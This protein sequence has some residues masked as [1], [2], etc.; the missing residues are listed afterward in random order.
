MSAPLSGTQSPARPGASSGLAGY[1][2]QLDVSVWTALELMLVR[3][4]AQE[5][6]LEPLSQ[7]DIEATIDPASPMLSEAVPLEDYRLVVQCKLDNTGPWKLTGL[8]ALLSHGAR[9]PSAKAQLADPKARY[10][11]IS[12]ADL[13]GLARNLQVRDLCEWPPADKMPKTLADALGPTDAAGRIAVLAPLPQELVGWRTHQVLTERFH[14]PL[15][16]VAECREAL[17]QQ[18]WRRLLGDLG[19]L[20]TRQQIESLL[21][22]FGGYAGDAAILE[23]FV[24]PTNWTQ[25]KAALAT[26]HAV[27]IT[28]PSGT[29]KTHT[30]RAL[31]AHVQKELPGVD[32]V[33]ITGG[34]EKIHLYSS[35]VVF[36]IEDPWG[37]FRSEPSSVPWNDRISDLL[38]TARPDRLF[39]ITSRSDV[40]RESGPK[41]LSANWFVQLE[42][43]HYRRTERYRLFENR[44]PALPP[45]GQRAAIHYQDE[46]L[47]EL[48]TPLEMQRYFDA[49]SEGPQPEENEAEFAH[50]CL[51]EA[52]QGSIEMAILNNLQRRGDWAWALF[53]WG[54]MKAHPRLSYK[55]LQAVQA[56]LARNDVEFEDG[57]YPFVNF[58][59]GGHQLRQVATEITYYHPRVEVGLG[60]ALRE[61]PQLGSRI[62]RQLIEVL[63]AQDT[64]NS[65]WGREG[66]ARIIQAVQNRPDLN[67]FLTSDTV[68][69]LDEWIRTCL[70]KP[71]EGF[72]DDLMLA[73]AVGSEACVPAEVVRWLT[74]TEPDEDDFTTMW[75]LPTRSDKWYETIRRDPTTQVICEAFVR[76]LL[77]GRSPYVSPSLANHIR[78]LAPD[79]TGAFRDAALSIV[80]DGYHSGANLIVD[81][82]LEDLDGFLPVVV[83]AIVF[84]DELRKERDTGHWLAILNGEYDEEAAEY[85]AQSEG[86]RGHT[87]D[88][89]LTAYVSALRS[90]RGW[91]E[92]RS[93]PQAEGLRK[94]WLWVAFRDE[95]TSDDELKVLAEDCIETRFESGLWDHAMGR[96]RDLFT[97]RLL[98]CLTTGCHDAISRQHAT[99]LMAHHLRDEVPSLTN[100]LLAARQEY[101][102]LELAC[103]LGALQANEDDA[104]A[105]AASLTDL[106]QLLPQPLSEVAAAISSDHRHP[107]SQEALTLLENVNARDNNRLML[108]QARALHAHGA[109][110]SP[111]LETLIRATGNDS[112]EEIKNIRNAV[113]LAITCGHWALVERALSHRFADVRE[114]ALRALAQQVS[115]GPMPANLLDCVADKGQ[116]VRSALIRLIESHMVP[117]HL[118]VL[119][120][121]SADTWSSGF[122]PYEG[123][124]YFTVAQQAAN[125]LLQWLHIDDT[126]AAAILEVSKQTAD[127]DVARTLLS[128]LVR[129]G[130]DDARQRVMSL[131]LNTGNPPRHRLAAEALVQESSQVSESLAEQIADGQLLHRAPGVAIP[132]ARVVGACASAQR[133]STAA[134]ALSADSR[135]QALLIPMWFGARKQRAALAKA[136]IARLPSELGSLL[137]AAAEGAT[138][139]PRGALESLGDLRVTEEIVVVLAEIFEPR[140]AKQGE[141]SD[142]V[143]LL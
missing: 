106:L 139:L 25:L 19:G 114:C 83:A 17:R 103:D 69:Q 111:L 20:W 113:E 26:R 93:H 126:S 35:P 128:S 129:N 87:A 28:G 46:A 80:D 66:A 23:G 61:K 56:G 120:R 9:R 12:N 81:G 130:T 10:L 4:L 98:D 5:L 123:K 2:Y 29:G 131:A 52:Q 86:E 40:L 47:D 89:I 42:P 79:L 109:N 122:Q 50:R 90:Q 44:R 101:R 84:E 6:T 43:E 140:K 60:Q 24:P 62:L 85:Y 71:G 58:L 117:E 54:L 13:D 124:A 33:H 48:T 95:A 31:I 30:A 105:A 36:E 102:L 72:E 68:A 137:Q 14:V 133:I 138:K 96:W 75:S 100:A 22:E 34:P 127:H 7:E 16:K 45:D 1:A 51:A 136:V 92:V 141:E 119:I 76:R 11:L 59:I 8:S 55:A 142:S 112:E 73:A 64:P 82:A 97:P 110:V 104:Q 27:I 74:A 32:V 21:R 39:I 132:L 3:K 99:R 18:A 37:R 108:A 78:R 38:R 107:L 88:R 94:H 135:R 77:P 134:R 115:D 67:L 15:P 70:A 118:A 121:L 116:R 49:L 53:V 41:S 57:L 125:A 63:I 65:D 143:E 91:E